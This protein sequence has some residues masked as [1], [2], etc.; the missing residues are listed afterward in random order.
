[1]CLSIY[2]GKRVISV[3]GAVT[4]EFTI[5]TSIVAGCAFATTMLR[6][7]LLEC[8]DMGCRLYPALT[9]FVYVDDIDLIAAGT[10][11]QVVERIAGATR[12]MVL[13]LENKVKA[14]VSREKSKVIGSSSNI[15]Q[16]LEDKLKPFGIS[17][18]CVGK[19]LGVDFNL[20]GRRRC[21]VLKKRLAVCRKRDARF[22]AL[23][24]AAG[25]KK[26]SAVHRAGAMPAALYGMCTHGASDS[27]L[28]ALRRSAA[29]VQG[30][31]SQFG[32]QRLG[33][34]LRPSASH[35]PAVAA[36]TLPLVAWAKVVWDGTLGDDDL[37][38]TFLWAEL[39]REQAAS[40]WLRVVGPAGAM[41]TSLARLGWKPLSATEWATD[42]DVVNDLKECCPKSVGLMVRQ[43]V[44]R[45]TWRTLSFDHQELSHLQHGA[46]MVPLRALVNG[47][48]TKVWTEAN[49]GCLEAAI[50]DGAPT[51]AKL[52]LI[53]V[54]VDDKCQWCLQECGDS[55]H[56]TWNCDGS[57]NFRQQYGHCMAVLQAA[58][59]PGVAMWMRMRHRRGW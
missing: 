47:R 21:A 33:F 4:A 52:E 39:R 23:R 43:G 57:L 46:D 28:K 32:S 42:E 31:N 2:A 58:A 36:H 45:W 48:A 16:R 35:D 9:F 24:K 18:G 27:H 53:D 20:T 10:E 6:V 8:L 41:V 15:R 17:T 40:P 55:L 30:I 14:Q 5:G 51:Q 22:A 7:V 44:V 34:L 11:D 12:F 19:K 29:R 1:M 25:R 37:Q 38:R 13:A 3:D 56:R 26:A 54:A 59:R 49:A 50:V